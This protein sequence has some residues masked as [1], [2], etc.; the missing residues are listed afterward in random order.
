MYSDSLVKSCSVTP[1][2]YR[3]QLA[4]TTLGPDV[5]PWQG[6]LVEVWVTCIL[7]LTIYGATNEIRK[8]NVY[9][10]TLLIGFAVAL[11][12]MSAVS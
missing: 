8:G 7:L 3:G 4:A 6:F 5:Q 9:M 11:G 12:I 1:A 10:P 2:Q